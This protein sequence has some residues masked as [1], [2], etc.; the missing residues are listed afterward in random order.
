MP[1]MGPLLDQ[2]LDS[3]L[4]PLRLS[5]LERDGEH[6]LASIDFLPTRAPSNARPDPERVTRHTPVHEAAAS[7]LEAYFAGVPTAFDLPLVLLGTPFQRRVWSEV[8][9]IPWGRTAAY[10]DI[11]EAIGS[12][13]AFRAVGAANAAN[14]IPIVVPCH[15]VIERAGG[16]RGYAGGLE[17]KRLLLAL[18]GREAAPGPLFTQAGATP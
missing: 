11:A 8:R 9:G 17:R 7:R 3:P 13:R 2:T 6:A 4:G 14:P 10:A 5:V 18:E 1:P 12:P 16:L 15:R